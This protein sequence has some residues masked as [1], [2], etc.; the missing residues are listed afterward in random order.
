[1]C[2]YMYVDIQYLYICTH[3]N[4]IHINNIYTYIYI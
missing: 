2:I 3:I 1:M 4:N